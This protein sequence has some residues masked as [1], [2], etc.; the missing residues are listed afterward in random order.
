[1]I[2]LAYRLPHTSLRYSRDEC[3]T[4]SENHVVDEVTGAYPS[5]VNLRD[6]SVLIVYY[7]EGSG[8]N[9]RARRFRIDREGLKWL[10][11]RD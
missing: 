11:L 2:V 1:M 5:L 6:G 9:I 10:P 7:E 3:V 8:S 4:W